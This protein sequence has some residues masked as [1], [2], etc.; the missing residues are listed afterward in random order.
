MD[1]LSVLL[2]YSKGDCLETRNSVE[3][4][5]ELLRS[6]QVGCSKDG[7][8]RHYPMRQ[9]PSGGE[10]HCVKVGAHSLNLEL[11][12]YGYSNEDLEIQEDEL[13][14]LRVPLV[15]KIHLNLPSF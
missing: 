2:G 1:L 4:V 15:A 14:E 3:L 6:S 10:E 11:H 5:A 9:A 13:M 12:S 8:H 7:I